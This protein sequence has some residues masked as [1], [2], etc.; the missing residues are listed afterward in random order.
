MLEYDADRFLPE[1]AAGA[2]DHLV[3]VLTS[4]ADAPLGLATSEL[5]MIS[6]VE[7]A[8]LL[9]Q[10]S[11]PIESPPG[12][13]VADLF[14]RAVA[15]SPD[16]PALSV[17]GAAAISYR[18][19]DVRANQLAHVLRSH[20]VQPDDIVAICLPRSVELVQ[21]ILAV[22]KAGAGY[23]PLDPD[24]PPDALRHVLVD[25]GAALLI[26][27]TGQSKLLGATQGAGGQL[28]VVLLDG[29]DSLIAS[30]PTTPPSRDDV[31][32]DHLA[33][34]IYTSGSTGRPK[35]V[36]VTNRSVAA[37]VAAVSR[38]YELVP[39]DRVLQ[40]ASVS[41]DVSVEEILPTLVT[42]AH[43]VLR[44]TEHVETFDELLEIAA[45]ERLTLLN[46]PSAYWHGLVWHL[47]EHPAPLPPTV[48]LVV[49]GGEKA[50]RRAYDLWSAQF[51]DVQWL[52]AY[53]PTEATVT[54]V[55]FERT[56][57]LSAGDDVPIGKPLSNARAYVLA[58]DRTLVPQGMAGELWIGGASVARGYLGLPAVT[59]AKFLPDPFADD[60]TA[61]MYRTGDLA[62][63]CRPGISSSS[64][65]SI[66]RSS[67][68][69]SVSSRPR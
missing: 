22:A 64:T 37:Y 35:G 29:E 32:P 61:R 18:A 44:R 26:T 21:S 33:Y 68:V 8:V 51:P 62:D 6:P 45:D 55:V 31:L 10:L 23:L 60:P 7:Q 2:V 40:F 43:L 30:Q 57:P 38:R 34:V 12:E 9:A 19:L 15:R 39:T 50:S 16:R 67:C 63:G 14:E 13:P 49:V 24:Y 20:G 25:A 28:P 69:V 66:G 5:V 53:G 56:G 52:N 42:G 11:P 47:A 54:C 41:F 4:I 3:Q 48:R 17:A 36:A 46:L 58:A 1:R 59:A 27:T 65:A